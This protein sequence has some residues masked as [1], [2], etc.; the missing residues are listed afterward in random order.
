MTQGSC[1]GRFTYIVFTWIY[2]ADEFKIMHWLCTHTAML[3][4]I[5]LPWIRFAVADP[6][7]GSLLNM[8]IYA[9]LSHSKSARIAQCPQSSS[10]NF[11]FKF[12]IQNYSII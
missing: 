5:E 9:N 3:N 2:H 4:S 11:V 12:V 6:G 7:R 1:L 10:Y 8:L